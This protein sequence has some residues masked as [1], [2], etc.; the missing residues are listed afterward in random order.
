MKEFILENYGKRPAFASFLPGIAGVKGVPIWC[1]YVNR[2]QGVVSF[3]AENKDQAIMEFYPAHTAW[4]NVKRTGFRTFLRVNGTFFEPFADEEV[5]HEMHIRKNT[6]SVRETD[7]KSGVRTDVRYFILPEE[8]F[9]ALV[10]RVE[11]K[12][13]SRGFIKLEILDGMPALIPAG[14]DL[15]M[16]KNMAQLV[17]A[18]MQVEDVKS[19]V[20]YYRVRASI[21][22]TADV[23][24]IEEGNFAFAQGEDERKLQPV[25]D[26]E[27]IFGYDNSLEN[28][29]CF[30]E[31]GLAA[32]RSARQNTSN[33]MPSGFFAGECGLQRGET[34]SFYEII[35][36]VPDR[37]MLEE[38]L[39]RYGGFDYFEEKY[40][41]AEELAEELTDVIA[42]GTGNEVFDEYCRYS[43]MDNALRGG[44]PIRLGSDKVFYVYSRKHGDLEREY[45]YFSMSPEFYSQGNGNFRDVNQNRRCDPFFTPFVGDFNIRLFYDLI[46]T[47]GCNPLGVERM[48]Y[49]VSKGKAA[50][51]LK[52]VKE[53]KCREELSAL[54]SSPFTPGR[55]SMALL[56]SGMEE[57]ASGKLFDK[58][59]DA[60]ESEVNADF[61]E[62]Y[63][64]DHWTYNLDL[65]EE[66]LAVFPD[67]KER[68]L[69]EECFSYFLSER[70]IN[71]RSK[72]YVR[73]EKGIRQYRALSE[74]SAEKGDGKLVRSDFGKGEVYRG[75][76]LEKLLLLASVKFATLDPW[77]MGIEM[78]GGRPGWYDA[79]NG[80]PGLFGSSMAETYELKRLLLFIKEV[81]EEDYAKEIPVFEELADFFRSVGE[82]AGKGASGELAFASENGKDFGLWNSLNDLKE[83]YRERVFPGISGKKTGLSCREALELISF[84]ERVTDAG[85][86][87]AQK[88]SDGVAPTYFYYEVKEEG[89]GSGEV[90][91]EAFLVKKLPD[92]LEGPVRRM[93]TGLDGKERKELYEAVRK[94]SLYDRQLSM[95]KVNAGL[96]ELSFEVGR[97]RCFTPGWLE[98]ESVWLHM[99]YKYLLEL[100]K[101]GLYEEFAAD[102]RNAA[103]PFLD[104]SVYGRSTLENSSFIASSANPNGRIRGRGFVARLSG[105]TA[106][107][108]NIWRIMMFGASP[109][110]VSP[111]DELVFTPS[112]VL[113][114][115]LLGPKNRV[116]ARLLGRTDVIYGFAERK[117]YFPGSYR[118]GMISIRFRDGKKK[119][120]KEEL[121]GEDAEALRKGKILTL[122]VSVR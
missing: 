13:I 122:E 71:P 59:M 60:A 16:I 97:A 15:D 120:V 11:L 48:T 105:S 99:E 116:K 108:L 110:T 95:Y 72:R 33:L 36:R 94:S 70:K 27:V 68:L 69:T 9:G 29:V 61:G 24:V 44:A 84:M 83:E 40:L 41:R 39:A 2:G 93:K 65:L 22:D 31:D 37:G 66:Y 45:N 20:P 5:H 30:K 55:L 103:V 51:L 107:F 54:V 115:Y 52:E 112:P 106:E 75:S 43:Y 32:L 6:F 35:G 34:Y 102:F 58:L 46:Q 101:G 113:P 117:D 111:E 21:P 26:P 90:V 47:D 25:V 63:W 53:K 74:E 14:V 79:L 19:G 56:S 8:T 86:G 81:L 80:L 85:I 67:R 10:R 76:L 104:P 114:E 109:F 78:E 18:W 17:K 91:P 92:F 119:T 82:A 42:S 50:S 57:E 38:F 4:Q 28:P 96:Q 7:Q 89:A 87:R 77:G 88:L 12:N 49:T 62:G 73:T 121:R 118:V 3:G 23:R 100:L 98:N 1:Y 64:T